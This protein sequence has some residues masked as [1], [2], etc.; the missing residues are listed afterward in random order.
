MDVDLLLNYEAPKY[1]IETLG[2]AGSKHDSSKS[3]N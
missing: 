2:Q 1:R 3:Q